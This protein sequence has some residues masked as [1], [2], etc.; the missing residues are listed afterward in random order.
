MSGAL[1]GRTCVITGGTFGIGRAVALALAR[2]GAS[3]VLV[4]RTA[5][6]ADDT[7]AAVR[8]AGA[9]SA[10]RLLGDLSSQQEVRRIA[11]EIRDR[12][13]CVHALVNNAGGLFLWPADSADGIEMTWALNHLSPFLL[14]NLLLDT[15]RR[16]APARIVNVASEAHARGRIDLE[17]PG[18]V[19]GAAAYYQSKLA[20]L[21][22]T[23]ELNRRL[24]DTGVT[25]NAV[26]PGCVASGFGFNNGWIWRIAR[27][28]VQRGAIRPEAAAP[29]VSRLVI[30]PA[31]AQVSGRYF[32]FMDDAQPAPQALDEEVGHRLWTLS[33][34]MTALLDGSTQGNGCRETG[35]TP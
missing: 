14:T 23:R 21:L 19:R 10:E 27:P 22:F 29:S 12:Y 8:R 35:K 18:R 3:L 13:E 11:A 4:G 7:V 25:A 9:R 32:D 5:G 28:F 26:H 20:N 16:S 30:D 2:E 34:R 1:D 31:L 17:D 24:L 15:L 6:H 33:A